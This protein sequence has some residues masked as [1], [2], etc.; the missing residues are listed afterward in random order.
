MLDRVFKNPDA[1]N[2]D[3]AVAMQPPLATVDVT[4]SLDQVFAD[5]SG[6]NAAVVVARRRPARPRSSRGL[7]CWST[8][9]ISARR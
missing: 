8:S 2:E 4:D 3:V 6:P 7:I 9:R 1:L 5:L